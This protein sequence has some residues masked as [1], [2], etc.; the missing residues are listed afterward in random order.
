M[1]L[2]R[3]QPSFIFSG[4]PPSF[5]KRKENPSA[6]TSSP[7]VKME[8]YIPHE[9]TDDL[10]NA[11]NQHLSS[12][13]KKTICFTKIISEKSESQFAQKIYIALMNEVL[14]QLKELHS[15]QSKLLVVWDADKDKD[16]G[17]TSL[18][19]YPFVLHQ[20]SL[21]KKH[22][23]PLL[24]GAN[25][26]SLIVH[27]RSL[28]SIQDVQFHLPNHV[29][30]GAGV[31]CLS[32]GITLLKKCA[33]PEA[34]DYFVKNTLRQK[35][36]DLPSVVDSAVKMHHLKGYSDILK[37]LARSG[38][39]SF[40]EFPDF[41]KL[42]CQK[43]AVINSIP[44]GS[45]SF[46]LNKEKGKEK[47]KGEYEK[48]FDPVLNQ[49][50]YVLY[51]SQRLALRFMKYSLDELKTLPAKYHVSIETHAPVA[52]MI[53]N[54]IASVNQGALQEDTTRENPV[55]QKK[56]D[57]RSVQ[58]VSR[59]QDV[60]EVESGSKIEWPSTKMEK[61]QRQVRISLTGLVD[62]TGFPI[63]RETTTWVRMPQE[64]PEGKD[65]LTNRKYDIT[66]RTFLTRLYQIIQ[67][68]GEGYIQYRDGESPDLRNKIFIFISKNS[69]FF[70]HLDRDKQR[71][72]SKVLFTMLKQHDPDYLVRSKRHFATYFLDNITGK[73]H[74]RG[75]TEGINLDL[76][77]L[78]NSAGKTIQDFFSCEAGRVLSTHKKLNDGY[79]ERIY[80]RH[81]EFFTQLRG[82][83]EEQGTFTASLNLIPDRKTLFKK[84]GPRDSQGESKLKEMTLYEKIVSF[85]A[86]NKEKFNTQAETWV[87][88]LAIILQKAEPGRSSADYRKF[89]ER[90]MNVICEK[91][92]SNR[93]S[94]ELHLSGLKGYNGESLS[95]AIPRYPL[96]NFPN[97]IELTLHQQNSCFFKA[98]KE[99]IERTDT[100]LDRDRRKEEWKTPFHSFQQQALAFGR[101]NCERIHQNENT[102]C[103]W[104]HAVSIIMSE[105]FK[106]STSDLIPQRHV[107]RKTV[108]TQYLRTHNAVQLET[109][110]IVD[111]EGKTLESFTF[112][113]P[114][115]IDNP[116]IH[117]K[118]FLIDLKP[119][120]ESLTHLEAVIKQFPPLPNYSAESLFRQKVATFVK[121]NASVLGKSPEAW[122]HIL[123]Y[124]ERKEDSLTEALSE[125][126][127][128]YR[129]KIKQDIENAEVIVIDLRQLL[130]RL[131]LNEPL[132]DEEALLPLRS[133]YWKNRSFKLEDRTTMLY[134]TSPKWFDALWKEIES[135]S[136]NTISEK[137]HQFVQGRVGYLT[138]NEGT[139][140]GFEMILKTLSRC[141]YKSENP[142]AISQMVSNEIATLRLTQLFAPFGLDKKL[143]QIPEWK[144][145]YLEIW[146]TMRKLDPHKRSLYSALLIDQLANL[147]F[148]SKEDIHRCIQEVGITINAITPESKKCEDF[149][150]LPYISDSFFENNNPKI[151]QRERPFPVPTKP[152]WNST[153]SSNDVYAALFPSKPLPE[154]FK[155]PK[156]SVTQ[157]VSL[158]LPDQHVAGDKRKRI[159]AT[160]PESL[161]MPPSKKFRDEMRT[162]IPKVVLR[163]QPRQEHLQPLSSIPE[164]TSVQ[165]IVQELFG[166][167]ASVS[168]ISDAEF[169]LERPLAHSFFGHHKNQSRSSH[170]QHPHE[171][172]KH[173]HT[174]YHH[175]DHS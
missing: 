80:K 24:I 165:S 4:H 76:N 162:P 154:G 56:E 143:K 21:G 164:R 31:G 159:P 63:R 149:G 115:A 110:G 103:A 113:V 58:A 134:Q 92:A 53:K 168:P 73:R 102:L 122:S 55:L 18:H 118:K 120:E 69:E 84:H 98:L 57:R 46:T 32:F 175:S 81:T 22:G 152:I 40:Y 144:M 89:R 138:R 95:M 47:T 151:Q 132:S 87:Y 136:G 35:Q 39:L 43:Q 25:E 17:I 20:D 2:S 94:L 79:I 13:G 156:K 27:S 145:L 51:K 88:I 172:S 83:I 8:L 96:N 160:Q 97:E 60:S 48:F 107:F 52:K 64:T 74:H 37:H 75:A 7:P 133:F 72:W 123:V 26:L 131:A 68:Y 119:N 50:H 148:L 130:N 147:V 124:I 41:L 155:I 66:N 161:A 28:P 117:H 105:S 169:P 86:L 1:M 34:L 44:D 140:V 10:I 141:C 91:Y 19:A 129:T 3:I 12:Q 163:Q 153:A 29:V 38:R 67:K 150:F 14:K 93:E 62:A 65:A 15:S 100:H 109:E 6:R 5:L 61:P 30:Q 77:G 16:S 11:V 127:D 128:R 42:V 146:N 108:H 125:H 166:T 158:C 173:L 49:N 82:L 112:L 99:L 111:H 157:S 170:S 135:Q 142:V 101:E 104:S 116:H 33:N 139:I 126:Y 121:M 78:S 85:A 70:I 71:C 174:R 59:K 171:F 36:T 90:L 45:I 114:K 106:M 9:R 54:P 167:A 137:I 23:I